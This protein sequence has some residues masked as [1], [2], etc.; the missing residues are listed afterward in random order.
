M[1]KRDL[2]EVLNVS[3]T[4][5]QETIKKAFRKLALLYHPDRNPG[6]KE[7]EEKFREAT[8]AYEI[9]SDEDKR[10][11]YDRYGMRAFEQGGHSSQTYEF[12]GTDFSSIFEEMFRDMTGGSSQRPQPQNSR[13]SDIK[14]D[15]EIPL[16]HIF[17]ESRPEIS[18]RTL[19]TCDTCDGTGQTDKSVAETCHH[20]YGS[21]R[22]RVQQGFFM[23]ERTCTS[24][25]GTGALIQNP[26][27]TCK[28]QGRLTKT[29]KISINIPAGIEE[30]TRLRIR[31][32]GEAGLRRGTAGDLYVF[33]SILPHPFFE[34]EGADLFCSVPLPMTK[35]AL[36]D[37]IDV[38]TIEGGKATIT[39]PEGTQSG[40]HLRLKGKGM[41][42]LQRSSRGDLI[43]EVIV[44]TPQNLTKKQKDILREFDAQSK[45]KKVSPQSQ[46]FL[47]K[48]KRL[49]A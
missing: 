23:M 45:T 42:I 25:Q 32:E 30:G 21:G 48:M 36:G 5:D 39:V 27:T 17:K 38:P 29:K 41:P 31:G 26:C 20:C 40:Q 28:G 49:W 10:A 12:S 8:S 4:A 11:A 14:Y 15:L 44:E 3:R 46:S 34:R 13:G 35:A 1:S 19:V 47:E 18:L 6:N 43:V 22:Q 24:C 16:E 9:L 37:K 2:Y 33:V 7:A